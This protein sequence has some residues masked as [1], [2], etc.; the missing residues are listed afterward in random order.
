MPAHVSAMGCLATAFS[1]NGLTAA[2]RQATRAGIRVDKRGRSPE[3]GAVWRTKPIR[4]I[5]AAS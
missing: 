1:A 2:R 3:R 4:I 5:R